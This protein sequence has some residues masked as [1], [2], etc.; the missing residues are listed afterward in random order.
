MYAR[1]V[2]GNQLNFFFFIEKNHIRVSP[3]LPVIYRAVNKSVI[4][5]I[6]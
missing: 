1:V 2:N 4:G 5:N 3:G 6:I